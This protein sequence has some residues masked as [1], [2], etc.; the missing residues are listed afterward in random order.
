MSRFLS[1]AFIG[2]ALSFTAFCES[3]AEN[4]ESFV[5]LK[6]AETIIITAKQDSQVGVALSG[7][8]GSVGAEQLARRPILRSGEVLEAVPGVIITQHAGGGKANQYFLRGYNLDH[9]TDFAIFLD[10]MPLN[11]PTHAHGEGYSDMNGVIPEFIERIDFQKGPYYA[12]VGNFSSAGNG[13]LSFF[14]S[15]PRNFATLE[16]FQYERFVFGYS[17]ELASGHILAGGEV[18]HDDGPWIHPDK[19]WRYNGLLSYEQGDKD[20]GFGLTFRAYH[21]DW[22]STDQIPTSFSLANFLD[23]IDPT[24]GGNSQRYS[25]QGEWHR[26]DKCSLTKISAYGFYYDLDLISNFT[27][28]LTD[29]NLGDQF[30]QT[31]TRWV[32]GFDARHAFFNNWLGIDFKNT[33]GLQARTDFVSA[34]LY[35]TSARQRVPK[36]DVDSGTTLPATTLIDKIT[37]FEFGFFVENKAQWLTKMR[38]ALSLRGDVQLFDVQSSLEPRNSGTTVSFLP[39]PRMS[40]IFG[41]WANTEIYLQ[42]GFSF[43]SNDG[44]GTTQT[45][46]PVSAANP[47][48]NTPATPIP[49]LVQTKGAEIS[50]RTE[51]FSF[52]NSTL[53]FWYLY[54]D[55]ELQLSGDTGNTDASASPSH[56]YGIESTN[57]LTLNDYLTIDLNV[58]YSLARFVSLDDKDAAPGSPGGTRVPEAVGLAIASGISLHDWNGIGVNV[59]LRYFGPRDLTSDGIFKSQPTLILNGTVSYLFGK[60]FLLSLSVLNFLNRKDHDIDY[61]YTSRE[62]PTSPA[63]FQDVFHP[64]EPTQVRLTLTA[65]F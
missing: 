16:A 18:F 3:V 38:T 31:D 40:L 25:L 58:S 13:R 65:Y 42:G 52:L 4:E 61:A 6:E 57:L 59:R 27:Y 44:R 34:A 60:D 8:E 62:S 49:G 47:L 26:S 35:Q 63:V 56:R 41:P 22:H 36:F 1:L 15:L 29:I 46:Q 53:S 2:V 10:G 28:F 50:A 48:P 5:E 32:I 55:S 23:T 7:N 14:K 20:N 9:G 37:D 19:Y 24:D 51:A 43:H 11:L 30:E 33:F 21:G 12:E 54:S 39:S 17:H 64:I 45:I